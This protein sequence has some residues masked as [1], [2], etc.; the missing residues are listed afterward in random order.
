MANRYALANCTVGND[1]VWLGSLRDSAS[2]T[3][4]AYPA[5]FS[6]TPTAPAGTPL[7]DYLAVRPAGP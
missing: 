1:F 5:G 3:V 2:A 7:G 4:I 6:V